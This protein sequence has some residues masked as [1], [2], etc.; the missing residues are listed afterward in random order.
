MIGVEVGDGPFG[1]RAW[2]YHY[3][4]MTIDYNHAK[5][6]LHNSHYGYLIYNTIC[7]HKWNESGNK[8]KYKWKDEMRNNN[9]N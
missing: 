8:N 1:R 2:R 9:E 3:N 4:V 6:C 5:E 7:S